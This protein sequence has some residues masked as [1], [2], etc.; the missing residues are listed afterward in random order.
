MQLLEWLKIIVLGIVEGIT[1]WLPISSTGHMILVDAFWKTENH[2]VLTDEFMNMFTVVIQFGAILAVIVLYF[3]K[4]WP[5]HTKANRRRR[6]YFAEASSNR[7][8][9]GIQRFCDNHCYMDK[10]ILWLKIAVSC[11]PAIIVGLPLD[12]WMDA[13]L[14]TPVVVALMLILYGIGF[15][16]IEQYNKRRTP[17]IN[18]LSELT[19]KDAALIGIFQVLALVPGTSRSGATILGGILIGASRGLAA[20]YTFF[21]AIPV[22]FGASLL[23]IVKFGFAFTG[24]QLAVLL[25]GMA[26]AFAVSVLAIKFLVGYIKKHDFTVFGWYRI[27]LGAIVLLYAFLSK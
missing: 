3:K 13:H 19:W 12:D 7:M 11:L 26:V 14:Y 2:P 17:R 10:I 18:K 15:I 25:L 5:F 4:L 27:V 20:E 9:C 6:S 1:E 23:K 16:L 21:L 8:I 22:M 24:T